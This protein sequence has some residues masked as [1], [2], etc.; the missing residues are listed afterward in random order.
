MPFARISLLKGKSSEYL[1]ALSDNLH[2]ALVDSFDVPANDRFQIFHQ[3]APDEFIFDPD[4]LCGPRTDDFVMI[5]LT[6]GRLRD[7]ATKQAFYKR[8]VEL[9]ETAPGIR[10]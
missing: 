5:T 7:T 8:L 6:A 2:R 4:Y 9:L 10:P 3:H 1:Q